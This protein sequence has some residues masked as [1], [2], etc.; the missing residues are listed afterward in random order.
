MVR[1]PPT[2]Q[3]PSGAANSIDGISPVVSSNINA[4]VDPR[5][6]LRQ[7]QLP[8]QP[9]IEEQ[10]PVLDPKYFQRNPSQERLKDREN[11]PPVVRD[12][13]GNPDTHGTVPN[14][15]DAPRHVN[16]TI[17][18]SHRRGAK[19]FPI[20]AANQQRKEPSTAT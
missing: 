16:S 12:R 18:P 17:L 15:K 1:K 2:L 14:G 7:R 13:N 20:S 4:P 11:N 19:P 5:I 8:S 3:S 10:G 9:V 6:P